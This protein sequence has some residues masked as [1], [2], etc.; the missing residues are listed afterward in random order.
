MD[1]LFD[2]PQTEITKKIRLITL[3]SGIGS[4]EIALRNI[5]ADFEIYKAV[6]W[7]KYAMTSYN[8]IH[9]T[10]FET[11]DICKVHA[12]DLEIVDTDKYDYILTYSYP[13]FTADTLI[14]TNEGYKKIIDVKP[15]DF[16]LTHRNQWQKVL[17]R[18][19][20][21]KH[22]IF[23][24]KPMSADVIECTENH[25]FY[26]R[27]MYRKYRHLKNNKRLNLR[28]FK[29]PVWKECK[30]LT[31]KDYLGIV[32]NQKS[33]IFTW[34]SPEKE[35]K[36]PEWKHV[37]K[38]D[39]PYFWWLM[40]YYLGDGW[41]RCEE[42]G[43]VLSASDKKFEK[44]KPVLEA[45]NINATVVR[46]RT[47]I[48]LHINY[49]ELYYF[50]QMF[51]KYAWG[52]KVPIEVLNLPKELLKSFLDGYFSADGS[53]KNNMIKCSSVSRELI[54][55]ISQCVYKV[56]QRPVSISKRNRNAKHVIEGRIVNQRPSYYLCFK[57]TSDKQDKAFYEDGYVWCP[58]NRINK[59]DIQNVYD[60]EVENDHSFTANGII[61]HNCTSISLAG[62]REGMKEGSG[63]ASSL[64]WEVKRIF[65]EMKD[66]ELPKI[67]VM[68][69]VPQVHS[70]QNIGEFE[71]WL[72]FLKSR[73]YY[74]YYQDLNA[75]DFGIP[76]NRD[77][78]FAVSILS[79]EFVDFE[80]PES[81]PL[82]YVMKDFLEEEVDDIYYL[83]S[84][85]AEKL[86]QQ[87]IDDG[88]LE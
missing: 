32:V 68:E 6:E 44:V 16:V 23:K 25:R 47:A 82:K 3:F 52:K 40:G 65:T 57:T 26:V 62:K 20:N 84:E 76:Q 60:I 79:K 13:C 46:E 35:H 9:G 37:I 75:K 69:N 10:N 43:I 24:I 83:N 8:A 80:F 4:Q 34:N 39:N 2:L 45:L 1:F 54:Y 70:P 29:E 73:G 7:D 78:C 14:L 42:L 86:I 27:E 22:Q 77:R 87:L 74:T 85:K 58:I 11:K 50:V 49:K 81:I 17:N 61:A 18:F 63:T 12:S 31:K 53:V 30:D 15:C 56:Y 51:G 33:E 36:G 21:G 66:D 28:L 71:R 41:Q 19:D 67:L 55:G 48:K 72:D 59:A 5:G 88:K 64:L 38:L